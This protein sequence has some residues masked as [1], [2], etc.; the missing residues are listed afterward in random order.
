MEVR[1][2]MSTGR[3]SITLALLTAFVFA[4]GAR[5]EGTEWFVTPGGSGE[6]TRSQPFG[7]VQDGLDAAQPGDSVVVLPGTYNERVQTVRSGSR[8]LPVR[9]M[10]QG[11]W[12]S[13][14]LTAPGR[15]MRIAH[16]HIHVEGLVID[17]QYAAADAVNVTSEGNFVTLRNVE[18][19]RSSRDL[20]DIGDATG[21]TIDASL[22]HHALNAAGGRTDAHGVVAGAVRDLTIRDSEIHTFSGDA[23]QVDPARSAPGWDRVTIERTRMW[24][25][26][27]PEAENG[28]AAGAVPGENAVDTK[29]SPNLPRARLTI[30][31]ST[32]WGFRGGFISNMAAFNVKENVAAT[33]DRVT[34]Y[35]SEIAFRLRGS[36][37]PTP[38]GALV[39]ISNAVVYDTATAFRY[40]D[41]IANLKIWNSTIGAGVARMFRQAGLESDVVEVRNLLVVGTLPAEAKHTSNWSAGPEVFVDAAHHDYALANGSS[42]IDAGVALTGVTTDRRGTA[43]PQGKAHDVGAYEWIGPSN[44]G[45]GFSRTK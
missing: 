10:A 9:V 25:A 19:R 35:D 39:T 4:A 2:S 7:R 29:A 44:V 38:G 42:V 27:L 40:E 17:G 8:E 37:R 30:R 22:I 13:V 20:I 3:I 12:G 5:A 14:L 15:V 41:N 33:I 45:S 28:F 6:G 18:V 32:A 24:L 26:P 31:D 1:E 11:A 36:G 34:V 23:F 16:A 43:R 21:V